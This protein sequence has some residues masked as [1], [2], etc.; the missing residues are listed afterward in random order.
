MID[1]NSEDVIVIKNL[2]KDYGNGLGIFDINLKIKKGEMV[3][4]VGTNGSGKTT[5]IR[6]IMGYIKPTS[7]EVSVCGLESW[8]NAS[9]IA[10]HIGYVPGEIA[11]PDLPTGTAFL[12]S[13]AEFLNLKDMSYANKLIEKLQLDPKANLK[14]MS[15]GMKQKTAL[16]AALMNN[17]DILILDEP[18]TGL[19]P[20]V[21]VAFLDIIKEEH[22]KGKTIFMSSHLFE[23]MEK[24]CDRVALIND[25]HLVDVVDMND[26]RN[27]SSRDFKIEFNNTEDFEK[28]KKMDFNIIRVQQQYNQVTINI[29]NNQINDL[30]KSLKNFKVKF[31]SEVKY[32]LEKYF[33]TVLN[34]QTKEVDNV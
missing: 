1:K 14:R 27:R 10:K 30:F 34:N 29:D 25:G 6:N 5:T 11:F 2:T 28:F 3:G 23:E 26:I 12:K 19:D 31:I 9:E 17:A 13:Q 7:G 33:K 4:F 32:S 18:T 24:T 22:K 16:V 8:Q 21:R 15:K 20:L